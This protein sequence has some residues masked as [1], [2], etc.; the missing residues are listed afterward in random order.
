MP[1]SESWFQG[2]VLTFVGSGLVL[3]IGALTTVVGIAGT[4]GGHGA[5]LERIEA[6]LTGA[7][8]T[9]ETMDA[10]I[11]RIDE[12]MTALRQSFAAAEL[13]PARILVE[14]NLVDEGA[15]VASAVH[16]GKL[17]VFPD[18]AVVDDLEASGVTP[19]YLDDLVRGYP[20]GDIDTLATI[21]NR[22]EA[23]NEAVS[24]GAPN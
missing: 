2:I 16:D 22:I 12:G 3:G 6:D 4:Q 9:L 13:D 19:S 14:M 15:V 23:R 1:L 24:E 21:A 5:R 10:R 17:W 7:V 11:A 8:T 18:S 20:I